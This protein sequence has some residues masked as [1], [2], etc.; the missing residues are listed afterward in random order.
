MLAKFLFAV[1]NANGR[2]IE[3]NIEVTGRGK[4]VTACLRDA[5]RQARS[6]VKGFVCRLQKG[7][8]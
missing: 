3:V 7:R 5:R 8:W 1:H 2:D 4:D 6:Y